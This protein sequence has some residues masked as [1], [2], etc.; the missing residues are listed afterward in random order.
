MT[1][2]QYN[3]FALFLLISYALYGL[4]YLYYALGER[5]SEQAWPYGYV[6]GILLVLFTGVTLFY[7]WRGEGNELPERPFYLRIG[8]FAFAAAVFFLGLTIFS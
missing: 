7:Y 5:Q 4:A 2:S 1:K 6:S 8:F 3:G